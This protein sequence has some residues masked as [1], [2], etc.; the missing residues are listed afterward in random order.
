MDER[1]NRLRTPDE[2]E[3]FAKNALE[4]GHPDLA[5][6]AKV[7]AVQLRAEQYGATS[8]AEREAL[9]A[10]YA[11]EEVL[12]QKNGRRTRASRTWQ[13][14]S[15]HGILGAVERAVDR[16]QETQGYV[17]L[18]EMGLEDF[19]FEA[20]VL[21]HPELFGQAAIEKSTERLK[22]WRERKP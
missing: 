16:E 22:A 2:C 15:R 10:V 12:S 18:V 1:V 8:E 4:R 13:M 3:Q 5:K 17:A 21:R 20:V 14:I 11:Y 19:A 9:Q 7:R 6:E